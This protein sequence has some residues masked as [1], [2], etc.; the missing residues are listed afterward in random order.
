VAPVLRL[1]RRHGDSFRDHHAAQAAI[2]WLLLDLTII[3]SLLYLAAAS[4]MMVYA[5]RAYEHLPAIGNMAPPQ[6]DAIPI[7]AAIVAWLV[8]VAVGALLA[9]IGSWRPIPMVGRL[10][11]WPRVIKLAWAANVLSLLVVCLIAAAAAQASSVTRDDDQPAEVYVL[12]DDMSWIP[13][14][15]INL[16]FYRV[17]YAANEKWGR[18]SVMV[19]RLDEPHLRSALEHGRMVFL[20][21]HGS[22]GRIVADTLWVAP[23]ADV[24]E[25]QLVRGVVTQRRGERRL[26][27]LEPGPKLRLVYNAACDSGQKGDAWRQSFAPAEVKTFDRLSLVAEHL[28]WALCTGPRLIRQADWD[29][30]GR[31]GD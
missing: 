24:F 26:E 5:R 21:C 9:A 4:T 25:N 17:S 7:A 11:K 12:Y 28:W 14:W 13:R 29:A 23:A 15:V 18:Q 2:L 3:G 10:L 8:M 16:G 6:R 1:F 19:A 30:V 22:D 31:N 27:C 20:A